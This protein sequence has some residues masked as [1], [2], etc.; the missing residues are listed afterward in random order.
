MRILITG[1]SGSGTTTL[2]KEFSSSCGWKFVDADEF[3]W[4]ATEPPFTDRRDSETRLRLI[5]DELDG[6]KD[7][8]ISGSI[9]NW[10]PE[11]EECFDLIVF[12]YLDADIRVNRVRKREISRFGKAN[13]EFLQ[14]VAEYDTGPKEGRSLAKH[15]SWLSKRK[16]PIV[17]IEDDLTVEERLKIMVK[18]LP[19]N[20]KHTDGV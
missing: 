9:M 17:R 11:L 13:S 4:K 8:V 5:L 19:N 15:N 14:W 1:A 6:C 16:C 18:A 20:S 10:G 12:L 2:G 7:I 3:F